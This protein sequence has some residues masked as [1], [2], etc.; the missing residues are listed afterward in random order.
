MGAAGAA[1]VFTRSGTAW[2][3][4]AY[5]KASNTAPA[6][7]FGADVS[8]SGAGNTLI[9]GAIGED[10]SAGGFNGDQSS[11]GSPS[12]GAA[13]LF[14][15][16]AGV[17]AQTLYIKPPTPHN[18]AYFGWATALSGDGNTLAVTAVFDPA[19]GATFLYTGH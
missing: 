19:G 14:S 4:E 6:D 10:S 8:L 5:I 11:N 3:F 13:Y 17:W 1:Y 7:R 12:S 2:S 16:S 18:A 9:V 15:R